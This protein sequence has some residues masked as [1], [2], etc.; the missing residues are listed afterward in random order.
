M[1]TEVNQEVNKFV[2]LIVSM[3]SSFFNP[4]MGAAVN[5][6]LPRI[7]EEFSLDAI[8]LSWVTMAYLLSAA[9]FLVP[10]AKLGDILGRKK[11]F[12]YGNFFF[13][14]T[15][16]LCAFADSGTFLI[17]S[18]FLQGIAGSM[19]FSTGMAILISSYPPDERGK[20]IGWNVSAVYVGLSA[21]PILGGILTQTLGWASIF[22]INAIVSFFITIAVFLNI[23]AEWVESKGEKFDWLGTIIYIPSMSALMYGFS[24][25]PDSLAV[26][27]T[28]SGLLGII[29][30]V[31][32]ELK[33]P[34]PLLNMRLFF[35][36]RA[37]G[38]SN[39]SAFINYSATFAVSFVLS[40][41]LQYSKNLSPT[42]A[43][44]ILISQPLLMAVVAVF[45]GRLS[46]KVSP[47]L[48]ATAGMAV[49]VFGLFMLALIESDSSYTFIISALAVL[50]FGF[51]LF[52]SPNTNVV[53]SSVTRNYFAIASATLSTMRATGM[54]FSM[55]I[56][57]LAIHLY[58][59]N[60]QINVKNL[61]FFINSSQ[62]IFLIFTILSIIGIFLS[63]ISVKNKKHI[64]HI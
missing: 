43:G 13:G 26:F 28:I 40:L 7:A 15:S 51:G 52:S 37:F 3:L 19:M 56:A 9:V 30:F 49:S 38:S 31:I 61:H 42:D 11:M 48:L 20:V 45:S 54:M 36:N 22:T 63:Y 44:I 58:I 24:K 12:L 39:L 2:V 1:S 64:Q 8:T 14:V 41:Y 23:K 50:G 62:L 10:L 33:H 46:D 4:M 17:I 55:A 29:I 53:M 6:A 27:C 25:L 34:Q 35:E 59:G 21:S 47:R 5:V 57:S 60:Q 16:L 32:I 18:R